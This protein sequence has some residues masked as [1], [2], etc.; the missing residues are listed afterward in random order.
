MKSLVTV[1]V[2]AYERPALLD[3]LISSVV[4]QTYSPIELCINDDSRSD[5]VEHIIRSWQRHALPI[6]LRY[7]RNTHRLGFQGN[8][9]ATL[10]RAR[11]EITV[12]LGD[13]D[14]LTTAESVAVYVDAVR[15]FPRAA[16][17]YPNLLQ[18]DEQCNRTAVH[19][20]FRTDLYC[21]PGADSL[22]A[23]WLRSVQI[24]GMAFAYPAAM[25]ADLFPSGPSLFPQVSAVGQLLLHHGALGI[26]EY[27]VAT[28]VTATQLGYEV[29]QGRSVFGERQ[30]LG[31]V[32]LLEILADL[33]TRAPAL[34]EPARAHVERRIFVDFILSEPNIRVF[35]G[36][37]ALLRLSRS[38]AARSRQ[39]RRS[40]VFC[41]VTV[42]LWVAPA[43]LVR[44]TVGALKA[45]LRR[46]R[47]V[48]AVPL[49]TP[50]LALPFGPRPGL[51]SEPEPG[52]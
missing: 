10:R 17:L 2:P 28:R 21:P 4:N 33:H 15:R 5:A 25:V 32:E 39:A 16:F 38:Y 11:G 7:R 49:A 37:A 46:I 30:R 43:W 35:S 51:A 52:H 26:N 44:L 18:I 42:W 29:A 20:Y 8:L 23:L 48:Q 50:P 24:A 47:G 1:C 9:E 34:V 13:D 45:V 40:P 31:A 6:A 12:V 27:L 36:R 19:R 3:Q 41:M 14:L 22:A